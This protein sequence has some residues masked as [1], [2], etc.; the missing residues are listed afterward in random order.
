ALF[1]DIL[2]VGAVACGNAL[3]TI[4]TIIVVTG[5]VGRYGTA[6]LA[7]YGLGSRLELMLIPISF[8]VGGALTALVGANRG[9]RQFARARRVA[10]AGGLAVFA[11]TSALGILVGVAPDLWINLFTA[12]PAA[13]EF[14]RLYLRIAG[15]FYG[16]FGL[17]MTLYFA[18]QGT[19]NMVWPFSAGVIR[20][21]VAAGIGAALALWLDAA[22]DWLFVCVALGLVL[23][24]GLIALSLLSRLWNPRPRSD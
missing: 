18:T 16:F 23:F 1:A 13:V 2:R 11:V 22:V 14:A 24:G 5:L 12:E 3:L 8:G 21:V 4:A 10:W 20:I 19:G 7:G 6:A 9:K 15:P 17:G